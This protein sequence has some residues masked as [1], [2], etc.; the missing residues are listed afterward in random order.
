MQTYADNLSLASTD[1]PDARLV[2][3]TDDLADRLLRMTQSLQTT[4]DTPALL[5]LFYLQTD[6]NVPLDGLDFDN[7]Q[8]G[9]EYRIGARS[10]HTCH[11]NL[12]LGETHLGGLT[13]RRRGK[14]TESETIVLEKLLCCLLYPLRNALLYRDALA[15]AQ[16]DSLTGICNRAALDE[17]L[18]S[19][20]NLAGRHRTPLSIVVFDIDHFKSINDRYGHSMGDQA[21]KT[22]VNCAQA[23]ARSTDMVFRYGGEEFVMLLRNTTLDGARLLAERIRRKVEKL[24]CQ[25]KRKPI[26]MTIS[27]GVA[28][29]EAGEAPRNLFERADKALYEAKRNGRNQVRVSE[30][31]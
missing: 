28:T 22:V 14:F 31:A 4:L 17:S 19:E 5:E 9:L 21:I 29:L 2:H 8:L 6:A 20:A 12:K 3:H 11:Y 10:R 18:V 23:C 7:G 27:V 1:P 15:L 25:G 16:K 26:T 13:F 24:E 30:P